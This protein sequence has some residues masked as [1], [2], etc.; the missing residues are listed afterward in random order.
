[1]TIRDRDRMAELPPSVIRAL[2]NPALDELWLHLL[3]PVPEDRSGVHGQTTSLDLPGQET[4]AH[5]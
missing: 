2:L 3:R 4:G 5:Q 1:M